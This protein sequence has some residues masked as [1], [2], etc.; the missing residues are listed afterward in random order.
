MI[1]CVKRGGECVRSVGL[2]VL[3]GCLVVTR[4]GYVVFRG[5][6]SVLGVGISCLHRVIGCV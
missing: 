3:R 1:S 2:I 4:G 6:G 5:E